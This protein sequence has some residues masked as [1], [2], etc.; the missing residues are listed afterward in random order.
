[1][2]QIESGLLV[3]VI[4]CGESLLPAPCPVAHHGLHFVNRDLGDAISYPPSPLQPPPCGFDHVMPFSK[5]NT[6][7]SGSAEPSLCD[8][9]RMTSS[10]GKNTGLPLRTQRVGASGLE[11]ADAPPVN[12]VWPAPGTPPADLRATGAG[13]VASA[14]T[15]CFRNRVIYYLCTWLLN[16][17]L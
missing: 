10:V 7:G 5:R 9:S 16:Y 6:H 2:L 8:D 14:S 13:S 11:L 4:S 3:H 12:N 15:A 17:S 1:M